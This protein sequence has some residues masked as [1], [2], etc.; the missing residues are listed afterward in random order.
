MAVDFQAHRLSS[1]GVG[2]DAQE[3]RVKQRP[4]NDRQPNPIFD[5][6][7]I[8]AAA[9]LLRRGTEGRFL[10]ADLNPALERITGLTLSS[11]KGRSATEVFGL[12]AGRKV[13]AFQSRCAETR[14]QVEYETPA[15]VPRGRLVYQSTL[16]PILSSSGGVDQILGIARD[17]TIRRELETDLKLANL[18]LNL[19]LDALGGAHWFYDPVHRTFE[20]SSAFD[21]IL[22]GQVAGTMS[23]DDWLSHVVEE[24]RNDTCFADLLA[25][26]IEQGTAEFRVHASNGETR[27]LRC[28]RQS[29]N[30]GSAVTGIAGIV[31]DI[32][33]EKR[34]E[35]DLSRQA[36]SDALTGLANRR[37][38]DSELSTLRT[39]VGLAVLMIDVDEFKKYNDH[40]GHIGGD[41]VLRSV[42][43][44]LDGIATQS[45]GLAARYGGEEFAILLPG[46]D[47]AHASIVAERVTGE[48]QTLAAP[49]VASARGRVSVSI[50]VAAGDVAGSWDAASLVTSAD[51]AL[52]QA[53]AS[54]RGCFR[55]SMP[56]ATKESVDDVRGPRRARLVSAA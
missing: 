33:S 46:K 32:T 14:S 40:Y 42:A 55:L 2:D 45:G 37:R 44:V 36:T 54:G 5:L 22:G 52:Y 53:K 47:L 43:Q 50:G 31:V 26:R 15:V 39:G 48:L 1:N 49:H 24:D 29:A 27:W 13:E 4:G 30:D 51:R 21:R 8:G 12:D 41:A 35:A 23:L 7:R 38:F 9:F 16:T 3:K 34:Q 18:R 10:Y 6:S 20:L 28:R 19:A 25:G 56:T 11:I 17:I